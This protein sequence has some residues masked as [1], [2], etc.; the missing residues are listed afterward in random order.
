MHPNQSSGRLVVRRREQRRKSIWNYV[1]DALL[2][3]LKNDDSLRDIIVLL[4]RDVEEN[5]SSAGLAADH[6]VHSFRQ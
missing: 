6:L 4:E 5:K 3:Q 2:T 1:S